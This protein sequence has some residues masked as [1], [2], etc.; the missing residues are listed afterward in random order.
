MR[1]LVDGDDI[2][3]SRDTVRYVFEWF[4]RPW[5]LQLGVI[6][7]P[8]SLFVVRYGRWVRCDTPKPSVVAAVLL[9]ALAGS[10]LTVRRH[11]HFI[12]GS[13]RAYIMPREGYV[14]LSACTADEYRSVTQGQLGSCMTSLSG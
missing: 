11:S 4:R 6:Q 1:L 12:D 2:P 9:H 3:S 10:A 7:F 13:E 5:E 14:C 8:S